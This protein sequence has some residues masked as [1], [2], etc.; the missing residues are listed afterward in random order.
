[1]AKLTKV[2]G[3]IMCFFGT[4]CLIVTTFVYL[5]SSAY[6]NYNV[7]KQPTVGQSGLFFYFFLGAVLL[8][9]GIL[10]AKDKV[11]DQNH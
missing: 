2:F 1:M 10:F 3:A 9:F 4:V 7:D 5:N 6:L 8:T 11:L